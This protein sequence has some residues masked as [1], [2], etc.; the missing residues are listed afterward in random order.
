MLERPRGLIA[1]LKACA[2]SVEDLEGARVHA[3][4]WASRPRATAADAPSPRTTYSR[5]L[6]RWIPGPERAPDPAVGG[7]RTMLFTRAAFDAVGS[8]CA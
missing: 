4:L 5:R 6:E 1:R 7:A 8:R 3:S 2:A